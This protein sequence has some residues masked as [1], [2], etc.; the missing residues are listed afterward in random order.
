MDK[1]SK[2]VFSI[3]LALLLVYAVHVYLEVETE[4]GAADTRI[5]ELRSLADEL[6]WEN[7]LMRDKLP[8]IPDSP[9]RG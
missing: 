4:L 2:F 3:I 1:F 5:A 9:P 8:D 6:R 7:E